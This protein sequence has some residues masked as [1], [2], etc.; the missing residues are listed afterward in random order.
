MS[1]LAEAATAPSCWMRAKAEAC[2]SMKSKKARM[3]YSK[4]ASREAPSATPCHAA[5]VASRS[6]A[7]ARSMHAESRPSLD[8]K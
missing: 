3:P 5:T 7:L 4:Y 8:P 1:L 6:C 2:S